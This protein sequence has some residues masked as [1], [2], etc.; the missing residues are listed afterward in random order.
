[1]SD[2]AWVGYY[3]VEMHPKADAQLLRDYAEHGTEA[4]FTEIVSRHSNLVYSAALRQVDS[5]D[6]AA[7]VAQCV[8]IGL[9]Q[10]AHS[11]SS[12]LAGDASLAGWLC[13]SARNVS[14]NLR[15]NE[16][17]RHSRERLAMED[18][19]PISETDRDWACLG[20]VL[21]EAMSELGESD[22]DAL[23]IRFF[24]NQDLRSVGRALGVSDDTAQK[25]VSRALDKLRDHLSHLGITT[26]GASLAVVLSSNT[27]HAAPAGLAV[28]ISSAATLAGTSAHIST[29]IAATKIITMTTIQK[30]LILTTFAAT[31][32]VGVYEVRRES[33]LQ[34]KDQAL[35]QQQ[36]FLARRVQQLEQ[37]RDDTASKLA[38]ATAIQGTG[39]P[40]R[41]QLELAKL[42][43]E[44]TKLRSASQE[45]AQLKSTIENDPT[46]SVAKSWLTRV[47]HLKDRLDQMPD[48]KI[49][50]LQFLS[51]QDWL[52]TVKD[53]EQ[54]QTDAG[55][56]K[57]LTALRTAAKGEFAGMVQGA[58]S[59][60]AQANNGLAP[61]DMAQLQPYFASPID[62]SVLKRYGMTQPGI[63]T[64]TV[65]PLDIPG[66][67]YYQIG[68]N[69]ININS[70]D[71]NV[72]QPAVDAYS[73]ANN[74]Q[75]LKDPSQLLP[76]LTTPAE[77]TA[78][79]NLIKN[80]AGK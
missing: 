80:N 77:Q 65:S 39:Q 54:L 12:R 25:R 9:A 14:L 16:L 2:F 46:E 7:E 13:R 40:R 68:V 22:Y 70:A 74:G 11:L 75:E 59:A 28:V 61:T 4:A 72:L 71:E 6:S 18:L 24:K 37:E 31:I 58:L 32:A 20:P 50:E 44:V 8:F 36:D 34:E 57:A 45:L 67:N 29:T 49:P 26:T 52:N 47:N 17:R 35:L 38:T 64:E 66:E 27:V 15:R 73:A 76:Y 78:L 33:H 42:R 62:G 63:L 30:A 1:L 21:D 48:Q 55:F 19:D 41:E 43:A 79:Q 23:V 53:S 60:Y 10:G 5:P 56:A 69:T 3:I 51:D